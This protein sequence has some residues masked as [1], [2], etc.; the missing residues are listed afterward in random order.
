MDG[1]QVLTVLQR[2]LHT[3]HV[4]VDDLA[5]AGQRE[6]QGHVHADASSQGLRDGAQAFLGCGDLNHD[7]F[8]TTR[9]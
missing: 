2:L 6:D 1:G 3:E 9:L 5:V 4:G 7:V 8:A